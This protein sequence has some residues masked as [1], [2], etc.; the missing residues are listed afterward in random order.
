MAHPQHL[1][2][3]A[4]ELPAE[5]DWNLVFDQ[6]RPW[7]RSVI[8][9]RLGEPQAVDEVLQE[10]AL[11]ITAGK[12]SLANPHKVA[13][14][15]YQIAVRQTL[16]YRRKHGRRRKLVDRYA[17][18]FQPSEVD[19]RTPD[20]LTWLIASEQADLFRRAM[21]NLPVRD[22]EILM[23]KYHHSW[24]YRQIAQQLG[25]SESAVETR[26]HRARKRLRQG[27]VR[28]QVVEN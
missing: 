3:N 25:V 18:A 6:N 24:S 23:L 9:A 7:L 21:R 15:M 1:A 12:D 8:V 20:P 27:L 22:C 13:P 26:L 2:E 17:D 19:A 28:Y 11:A 14:W 10:V 4:V 5:I 16:L